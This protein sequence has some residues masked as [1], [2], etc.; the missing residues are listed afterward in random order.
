MAKSNTEKYEANKEW[1]AERTARAQAKITEKTIKETEEQLAKYYLTT[2]KKIIGQFE[3]TYNK[4]ISSIAEGRNPTPADL[5]KLDAYWKMEA[6]VRKELTKLG[7]K[8]TELLGKKFMEEWENIYRGIAIKDDLFFGE[9]DTQVAQQMINSVWCADGK[10]WSNRVWDN[11]GNLQA[12]LNENLIDC[13]V[14]GRKTSEL[15]KGLQ[16]RFEVSFNQADTLVRTEMAHIQT[17]ASKERYKSAGVTEV[18]VWADYDERRCE[19]CGE[20][21]RTKHDINGAMPVPAH[22]NCRCCIVPVI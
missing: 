8:Q 19:I 18:E 22:P 11:V 2:Q 4:V 15:K 17:Q 1:W 21:H 9:I 12:T 5:Y 6:Q 14:A 20:L 16:E 3:Q 7:D 10:T 13:L